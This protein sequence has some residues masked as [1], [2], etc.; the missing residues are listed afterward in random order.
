MRNSV[1]LNDVYLGAF[2]GLTRTEARDFAYHMAGDG[3][4][5]DRVATVNGVRHFHYETMQGAGT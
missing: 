5:L 3:A 1:I 2:G 4:Y